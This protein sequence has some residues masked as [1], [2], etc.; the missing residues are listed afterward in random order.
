MISRAAGIWPSPVSS[1]SSL[2][3]ER[4]S[5]ALR[6]SEIVR[7]AMRTG[8]K[9]RLSSIGIREIAGIGQARAVLAVGK[10]RPF[11]LRQRGAA[12]RRLALLRFVHPIIAQH[13]A[14][15]A[16]R[17]PIGDRFHIKQRIV[18]IANLGLPARDRRGAG[19]IG[20]DEEREGYGADKS[21][22]VRERRGWW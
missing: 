5:A 10:A 14:D 8:L 21:V 15:I 22:S 20:R 9:A 19:V 18:V 13:D 7:S 1:S 2:S 12:D 4:S 6:L 17:F 3:P 11:A 16:A